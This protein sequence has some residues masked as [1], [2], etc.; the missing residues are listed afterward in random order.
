MEKRISLN[1]DS[2]GNG[3][4]LFDL[5]AAHFAHNRMAT[6]GNPIAKLYLRN[7]VVAS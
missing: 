2:H 1:T 4:R 6:T 5:G 3:N 7:V